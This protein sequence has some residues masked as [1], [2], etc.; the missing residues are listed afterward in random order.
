MKPIEFHLNE[1]K[2]V[3]RW[4]DSKLPGWLS[5]LL[6]GYLKGLE[7]RWIDAKVQSSVERAIAPH[8]PSEPS[9]PKPTLTETESDV[10]GLP[11]LELNSPWTSNNSK[12]D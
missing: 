3:A 1:F 8:R 7:D 12:T 4:L 11:T 2:A 5:F 6:R 10:Q 9:L